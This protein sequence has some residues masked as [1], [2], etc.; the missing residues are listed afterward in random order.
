MY[1]TNRVS[2]SPLQHQYVTNLWAS[3][4]DDAHAGGGAWICAYEERWVETQPSDAMTEALFSD[5]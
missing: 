3:L 5:L 4:R 1:S 2:A